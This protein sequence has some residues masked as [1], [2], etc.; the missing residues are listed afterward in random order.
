MC[1]MVWGA[2]AH[3]QSLEF[4]GSKTWVEKTQGFG[5]FSSIEVSANGTSFLA[6]TDKGLFGEGVFARKGG[7]ITGIS[8]PKFY[9]IL[10]DGDKVLEAGH[11]DAEGLAVHGGREIYVSFEGQHVIRRFGSLNA[12]SVALKSPREF[13]GMQPNSSL[14][15]LAVDENGVLYTIPERSGL[16]NRPFPVFRR[17]TNGRWDSLLKIPRSDGFLPVGADFG[18]DGRFYLLERYFNGV[19]GFATRVRS[20]V[21]GKAKMS[22]EKVLL[23][24]PT[25]THDNLEGLSVWR[26]AKGDIRVTMISDDNFKFFQRTEFVEYRLVP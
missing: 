10:G 17:A 16:V 22:D 21:A 6:T 15:A 20:F 5:G 14:E 8:S 24:T 7:K 25:G 4:V 2:V 3:G 23:V 1:L 9:K 13:A 12:G 18:P 19:S 11:T 26:D